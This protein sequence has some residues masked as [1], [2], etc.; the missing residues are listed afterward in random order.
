MIVP[1]W[2]VL[3]LLLYRVPL[4]AGDELDRII[5][6]TNRM[7]QYM[8]PGSSLRVLTSSSRIIHNRVL[9]TIM[10]KWTITTK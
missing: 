8:G 10:F 7:G 5:R 6:G 1:Y 3:L 9:C 4:R 2:T